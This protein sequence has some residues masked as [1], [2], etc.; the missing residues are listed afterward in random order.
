MLFNSLHFLLFFPIVCLCYFLIPNKRGRTFLLLV[1]SYYFYMCWKPA[2]ALLILVSTAVTY[3]CALWLQREPAQNK[4][5]RKRGLVVSVVLNLSIL[6]F[7]KY[8]NFLNE[9]LFALMSAVGINWRIPNLD[10]LLP[11]G[12]S[13]YIFQA[14]GYTIDVYRGTIEAERDFVTYA[15]FV[16]FFPQLVAGPIERASH[17]LPQFHS[18]HSFCYD[19]VVEGFKQMLWGYFMKLCVAD[20]VAV[21]VDAV[22]RYPFMHSGITILMA[23]VLFALQIYC[24]FGGYSLIA[25]GAARVM[26]FRLMTNFQQPYFALSFKEFWKR[27][28]ISL[29]SWFMDYLYIPLGGNRVRFARHLFNLFVTF[30]VSGLWHGASWN[31]VVWGAL[32]GT[33]LVAEK[34]YWKYVRKPEMQGWLSR[35][36]HTVLT[37]VVVAFTWLFFRAPDLECARLMVC[38]I[39]TAGGSLYVGSMTLLVSVVLGV[40]LLW[41]KDLKEH[42]GWRFGLLHSR[43]AV[44]RYMSVVMLIVVILVFGNFDNQQFIYFQF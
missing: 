24:D 15:L 32:H 30:L 41:F 28:H 3:G 8:F 20:V 23:I 14:V 34:L 27:W 36:L 9:N 22:F 18:C 6:F 7:F 12:I 37:F 21:Y 40:V 31:F 2:Y 33:Y 44:V 19:D 43:H 35:C 1:S 38:R 39:L 11:V 25:I 13:F 16:S 42:H 5:R 26:G 4:R 10:V 17:L 29:S